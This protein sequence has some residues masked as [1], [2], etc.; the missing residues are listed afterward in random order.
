MATLASVDALV[1]DT[2]AA[3]RAD[4]RASLYADE[5][6]VAQ[7]LIERWALAEADRALIVT[8]AQA[9]V[10]CA[11]AREAE[12]GLLD[13]FL[14]QFGLSTDEGIAL[15]SLAEALLRVSD[16][17][18]ADQLI[19]E[20]IH[21]GDWIRHRGNSDSTLVNVA[22]R[23]L[24]L[25]SMIVDVDAQS[26]DE[27]HG[28]IRSLANRLGAPIVRAAVRQAMRLMGN[29]FVLG[30]TI[31]EALKRVGAADSIA[32]FDMLGEGA[33]TA[34]A[35][36][37]YCEAYEHAIRS[38]AAAN[39]MGPYAG[40]GVSVKLSALHPRYEQANKERVLKELVPRLKALALQARAGNIH[41]NIDAEEA[42]RL[43][44]S[45][46]VV[47]ALARDADLVGWQGLGLAV[48]SYSKRA[49]AVLDW[50]ITLGRATKHRFMVRLVKGAYWD[51]EIKRAQE[52][53]VVS[54]PVF[55]RKVMTDLSYLACARRALLHADV[56]YP[57]FATHNAHTIAA[58]MQMA[59]T[60]RDFEFQ[61]LHGMG[62]LLYS[63]AREVLPSLPTV[64]VYAPVGA[65]Q[66]LLAYLVRRLLEN[67][68]NTSFVN[69]FMDAAGPLDQLIED[70]MVKVRSLL[71]ISSIPNPSIPLPA[72]LYGTARRNSVGLD[73]NDPLQAQSL[74]DALRSLD[75]NAWKAAPII[76][77][78]R[79]RRDPKPVINPA[80]HADVV[81]EVAEANP[82]DVVQ[83]FAAAIIAQPR[84]DRAGT[85]QAPTRALRFWSVLPRPS[86]QSASCSC[87]CSSV[88]QARPCWM[89]LPRCVRRRIFVA[90]TRARHVSIS[91]QRNRS[92]VPR[93][94]RIYTVCMGAVRSFASVHGTS[95]W[96]FLSD[97]SRRHSLRA[98][99]CSRNLPNRRRWLPLPRLTCYTD[100]AYPLTCFTCCQARARPSARRSWRTI[101]SRVLP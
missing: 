69:R 2:L 38:T 19:A 20:K 43:D 8:R 32:S 7:G 27:N 11:R 56:I 42:A 21:A 99:A 73:L 90:T 14:Q 16:R 15:L 98:I 61:R 79:V 39:T 29:E 47:E 67:G 17:Q 12:R 31:E 40:H 49:L 101:G 4:I 72:S 75:N 9:V 6:Q 100:R 63:A 81:G 22:T 80:N 45:L 54:Y 71:S 33:R 23:A 26:L 76:S 60:Q 77:G 65:H 91:A 85:A 74:L 82:C 93:A 64:R 96:P 97:R 3:R 58:I 53:G 46:G 10:R 89:P 44:L 62:Q 24:I 59:G 34:A 36:Q 50:L 5:A 13:V 30:R 52:I 35:A 92:W 51:T 28:A 48:Q 25:T 95:P 94:S 68:A 37:R 66:D 70:P 41:L 55:T 18:T 57:Q 86:K 87:H 84:W 1:T 88:K 83:A 78:I